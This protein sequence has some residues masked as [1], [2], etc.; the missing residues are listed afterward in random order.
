MADS[1]GTVAADAETAD[2]VII[3]G[4]P[5]GSALALALQ[6]TGLRTVLLEARTAAAGDAR[7]LA[8]SYG[9]RLIL[10]RLGV[11]PAL[12]GKAT[13]IRHIH[14]SQ[15][16]AF[17]RVGLEAAEAGLPELGYVIEYRLLA[18]ELAR[19]AQA[20]ATDCRTGTRVDTWQGGADARVQYELDGKLQTLKASLIVVADGSGHAETDVVDY[21]QC[22]VTARV[23]SEHPHNNRAYER[24]TPHGP[25]ALL[26][27]GDGWAL[28][29]TTSPTRAQVLCELD[30]KQ[31]LHELR[32]EFGSRV[33]DF[34]AVSGRANYPL[35]LRR[36]PRTPLDH[37][38]LIGN[39]AQ[40]LHPVAGQGFNLGLRDAWELAE[41][42]LRSKTASPGSPE[43]MRAYHARRN[44]DR[45]GGIGITHTLVQL[46]SNDLPPL[47]VA[48]GLGLTL[49][50]C[51]PPL[52]NFL[53]RRMTF[54]A[55]G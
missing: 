44:V 13:P 22:A 1:A 43:W 45:S 55:R 30:S 36:A 3:G 49:L 37:A 42:A 15:R 31:F 17:G 25:L 52:K 5:V 46:F 11:W 50:G 32:L 24:F 27:D 18:Q 19:A 51:V 10:E 47:R 23:V 41:H 6:P 21:Q 39:A 33:G 9:T 28:V 16:G 54:G 26:P 14:V 7:P 12:A 53:V 38:V 40:T 2:V 8:L 20:A 4:G 29:W 35:K 34:T 48:R